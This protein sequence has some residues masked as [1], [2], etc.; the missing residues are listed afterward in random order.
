MSA[1]CSLCIPCPA[2]ALAT[3][4]EAATCSCSREGT[5]LRTAVGRWKSG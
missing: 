4:D 2:V 1:L 5:G 3:V